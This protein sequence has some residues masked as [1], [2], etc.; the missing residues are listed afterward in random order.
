MLSSE[1][2]N[3]FLV[4]FTHAVKKFASTIFANFEGSRLNTDF[5]S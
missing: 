1:F 2:R 4:A 5:V 3:I